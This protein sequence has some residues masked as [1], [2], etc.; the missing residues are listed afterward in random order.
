MIE[1]ADSYPTNESE[2]SLIEKIQEYSNMG[3]GIA[4]R[5]SLT[6]QEREFYF[7][8]AQ[9]GQTEYANRIQSRF[10]QDT[11]DLKDEISSLKESND[12]FG[13]ISS[14]LSFTSII[15]G[16]LTILL[17]GTA[18]WYSQR[19]M[20]SDQKWRDDQMMELKRNNELLQE[21]LRINEEVS[22]KLDEILTSPA[23]TDQPEPNTHN[24]DK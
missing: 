17:A 19:D 2:E 7:Q 15:L 23:I 4:K 20:E 16:G 6:Y 11:K 12:K 5:N 21:H 18:I 3:M 8:L 1:F 22:L 10:A 9:I 14:R 24:N 13:K